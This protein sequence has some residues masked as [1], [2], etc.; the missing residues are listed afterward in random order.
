MANKV[1]L[2]NVCVD[3]LIRWVLLFGIFLA[4]QA[5]RESWSLIGVVAGCGVMALI[6]G[7]GALFAFKRNS[8][9][10]FSR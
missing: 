5:Y 9:E 4:V 7:V 3:F 10:S 1:A 8:A 2:K 6:A